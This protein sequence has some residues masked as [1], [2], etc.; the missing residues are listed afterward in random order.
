MDK[1][2]TNGY[3]KFYDGKIWK[4]R[5]PDGTVLMQKK[6]QDLVRNGKI[7]QG[8]EIHEPDLEALEPAS[9]EESW[10]PE[11]KPKAS[12]PQSA[13]S[14]KANAKELALAFEVNL[15][16]LTSVIALLTSIPELEM[17]PEE[18]KGISTTAANLFESSSFNKQFGKLVA[19]SGDYSMLG[20]AIYLYI[21][22]VTLAIKERGGLQNASRPKRTPQEKAA[23]NGAGASG[24][25]GIFAGGNGTTDVRINGAA[26]HGRPAGL[27]GFTPFTGSA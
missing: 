21:H 7:P 18:A 20:Y 10:M 12:R 19:N 22:R 6:Y 5:A 11:P 9:E 1:L 15:S 27:R 14:Q 16:I 25:A 8:S 3:V 2:F 24:G 17:H 13:N 23:S 4:W 26:L